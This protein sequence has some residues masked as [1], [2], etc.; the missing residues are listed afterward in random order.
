MQSSKQAVCA[1]EKE[2]RKI[3]KTHHGFKVAPCT[4]GEGHM[5]G[6]RVERSMALALVAHLIVAPEKALFV[7]I[8]GC[9]DLLGA[10][11]ELF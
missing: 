7:E 1:K 10:L 9:L 4:S 8:P 11:R 6:E 2:H 3:E 5:E